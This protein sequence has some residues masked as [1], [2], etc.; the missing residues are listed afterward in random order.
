MIPTLILCLFLLAV[1][2]L[3]IW[4]NCTEKGRKF[5]KEYKEFKNDND[6]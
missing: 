5:K 6:I 1:I 4:E 3:V 2:A